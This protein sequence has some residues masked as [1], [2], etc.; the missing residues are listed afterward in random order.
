MRTPV[1]LIA[2][3]VTAINHAQTIEPKS[4]FSLALVQG[5]NRSQINPIFGDGEHFGPALSANHSLQFRYRYRFDARWYAEVGLGGGV[6]GVQWKNPL[7]QGFSFWNYTLVGQSRTEFIGGYSFLQKGNKSL[8]ANLGA[9]WTRIGS[10]EG[11]ASASGD[12]GNTIARI[13]AN[14]RIKPYVLAGVN[15][16]FTTKRQDQ[17]GLQLFYQHGFQPS[18]EGNYESWINGNASSGF[19]RQ[20][21]SGVYLGLSYTFTRKKRQEQLQ[22]LKNS[23]SSLREARR[24]LK[25]EKRFIDPRSSFVY[26]GIGSATSIGQVKTSGTPFRNGGFAQIQPRIAFEQGIRNGFFWEAEYNSFMFSVISA[27]KNDGFYSGSTAFMGHFLQGGLGYRVQNKKTLF[28]FF[29]I[30]A[31]VGLGV[32]FA[33][34]SGLSW[35]TTTISNGENQVLY[36]LTDS[37]Y[38][39]GRLMPIAYLAI[40]KDIRLTEKLAISLQFKQQVGI[41]AVYRSD[42]TY[43]EPNQPTISGYSVL[44]GT[45]RS[46]QLGFKYRLPL[47]KSRSPE[48]R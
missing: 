25:R 46:I 34:K 47:G 20:T 3:L 41:N 4:Q 1:L 44:N 9:G 29:N 5:V 33:S 12:E 26:A 31:G 40:S 11:V 21:N 13:T 8:S 24:A 39:T 6:Q 36:E 35:G 27:I 42:K 7:T 37:S 23:G 16:Q 38:V 28:Q 10:F 2:L 17:F 19:I 15:Y 48:E 30:H 22:Q 32:H 18:F 14:N 45:A 43:T